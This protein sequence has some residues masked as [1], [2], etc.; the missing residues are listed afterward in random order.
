MKNKI[1]KKIIAFILTILMIMLCF[2]TF[3]EATLDSFGGYDKGVSFAQAIINIL[4][5]AVRAVAAGVAI[6]GITVMGTR[7]MAAAPSERAEIKDTI[8][9]FVVGVLLVAG[10]T[11]VVQML[12][13]AAA[14]VQGP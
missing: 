13:E 12:Q 9:K 7:Y 4:L 11:K 14:K 6:M 2:C 3:A 10:A 5:P 1:I 8:I